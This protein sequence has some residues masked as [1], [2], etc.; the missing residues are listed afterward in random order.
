[1]S[2]ITRDEETLGRLDTRLIALESSNK[3]Q[4]L[5]GPH[6]GIVLAVCVSTLFAAAWMYYTWEVE[7]I[8]NRHKLEITRLENSNKDKIKWLKEQHTQNNL[9]STDKC[10]VEKERMSN[11]LAQCH[12]VKNITNKDII[13]SKTVPKR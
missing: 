10:N 3:S 4:E 12:M 13:I 5:F 2:Q 6:P 7:R 8:D 9:T 1:L 11:K